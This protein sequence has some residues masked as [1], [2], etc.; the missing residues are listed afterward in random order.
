MSALYNDT[1]VSVL[2]RLE[3]LAGGLASDQTWRDSP[4]IVTR[5]ILGYFGVTLLA[6]NLDFTGVLWALEAAITPGATA[7]VGDDP[8]S[9]LQRIELALGGTGQTYSDDVV[10]VLQ[11]I[12]LIWFLPIFQ[13]DLLLWL[14][15]RS[16]V[17]HGISPDQPAADGETV[18]RWANRANPGHHDANQSVGADQALFDEAARSVVL[19]GS[20]DHFTTDVNITGNDWAV[21][22]VGTREGNGATLFRR[23]VALQHAGDAT[24]FSTE[25]SVALAFNTGGGIFTLTHREV[26]RVQI[27]SSEVIGVGEDFTTFFNASPAGTDLIVNGTT[28][29]GAALST[30]IN[31][32]DIRI[33]AYRAG[34]TPAE[35]LSAG[36]KAVL[37]FSSART[38]EQVE[39]LQTWAATL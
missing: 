37:F 15:G 32:D 23:P 35:F 2:Q 25:T 19:D 39:Q 8:V 24:D 17:L 7:Q 3:I 26:D 36:L 16:G 33:G 27:D 12:E 9:V 14:D 31:A 38:P 29:S 21:L 28:D 20:S 11:R 13:P 4:V 22:V 5:R 10:R 34:G 1:A 6:Y 30:L 18:R